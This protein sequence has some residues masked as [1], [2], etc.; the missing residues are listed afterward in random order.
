MSHPNLARTIW[1]NQCGRAHI[2]F[3]SYMVVLRLQRV[4]RHIL[5]FTFVV[6]TQHGQ[7]QTVQK[8]SIQP[9]E[10]QSALN[11]LGGKQASTL[12]FR[13]TYESSDQQKAVIN[14]DQTVDAMG[15][16]KETRS[17]V[18]TDSS[19]SMRSSRSSQSPN[20]HVQTSARPDN[21][22][23]F[24]PAA[25]ITRILAMNDVSA[26]RTTVTDPMTG[27]PREGLLLTSSANA[28]HFLPRQVWFFSNAT[29]LPE[30]VIVYALNP[31]GGLPIV[32][33][34]TVYR[35]FTDVKGMKFPHII[36]QTLRT[37]Q[38]VTIT[39]DEISE[40]GSN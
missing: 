31:R 12:H 37:G 3:D 22:S 18:S 24:N 39:V 33:T 32:D 38:A 30:E 10:F 14:L 9:L 8:T 35:D 23:I 13:T 5:L 6:A 1:L 29:K 28:T 25:T 17:M 4:W 40:G 26:E 36:N 2:E 16:V 21:G 7:S 19:G 34:V 11:I 15:S 27:S 20:S